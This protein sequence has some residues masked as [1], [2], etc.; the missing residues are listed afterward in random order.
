MWL[1]VQYLGRTH[2]MC[3][4]ILDHVASNRKVMNMHKIKHS[5]AAV[6]YHAHCYRHR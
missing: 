4:T 3:S 5:S 6:G 1:V 2:H